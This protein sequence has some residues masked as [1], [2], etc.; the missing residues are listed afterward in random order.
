MSTA[1]VHLTPL[2][3]ML[4]APPPSPTLYAALCWATAVLYGD[5]QAQSMAHALTCTDAFPIAWS[6][7]GEPV[8]FF[9]MPILPQ[10]VAPLPDRTLQTKQQATRTLNL[11]KRLKRA[12]YLSESLFRQYL[13]GE[14]SLQSL[15][16]GLAQE[17]LVLRGNCLMQSEEAQGLGLARHQALLA[18]SDITHN[19][20]D[21]WT[22]AVVEGRL[23]LREETFLAP[24]AGLWFGVHLPTDALMNLLPALLRYLSDTGVGGERTSGKGQFR[25]TLQETAWQL[26]TSSTA[27]AWVSLSHYLPTPEEVQ[28]WQN[29]PSLPRY[30]LV[31][32]QA[33][34][35]AMFVGGMAVYKPLRRLL[36]P[37]SVLPLH[38]R[39]EVYGRIVPSGQRLGHTVWVGGRALPA[40]AQGG[41]DR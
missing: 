21:R 4:G 9:P 20:I 11:H 23:F 8:R 19:E 33:K 32:W 38:E 5:Q 14:V 15:S 39:R 17:K 12:R 40:F 41:G 22:W 30:T 29:T 28:A 2:G 6:E 36:A 34:Y 1:V 35:E 37:G 25:F 7:K 16:E 18:S 24:R 3:S 10:P 27:N 13:Q 26:P 31:H